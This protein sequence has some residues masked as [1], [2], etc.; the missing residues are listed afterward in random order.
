M[1]L[2]LGATAASGGVVDDTS[3]PAKHASAVKPSPVYTSTQKC[4][5]VNPAR[6][7]ADRPP[8]SVYTAKPLGDAD[9]A[10][11]SRSSPKQQRT[12]DTDLL[13]CLTREK[14]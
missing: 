13:P 6:T 7:P 10:M 2:A 3:A 4:K 9:T 8:E 12:I 5:L 1:M 11:R 14:T